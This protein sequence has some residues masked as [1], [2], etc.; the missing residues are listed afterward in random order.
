[1]LE[2]QVAGNTL[3]DMLL[4]IRLGDVTVIMMNEGSGHE[5]VLTNRGN[6]KGVIKVMLHDMNLVNWEFNKSMI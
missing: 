6:H 5:K 4:V 3:D 1:M 2:M